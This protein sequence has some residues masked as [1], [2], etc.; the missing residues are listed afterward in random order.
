MSDIRE[1]VLDRLRARAHRPAERRWP[2]ALARVVSGPFDPDA[3]ALPPIDHVA[4]LRG[5]VDDGVAY[6]EALFTADRCAHLYR[7]ILRQLDSAARPEFG[8]IHGK[9]QRLD[10]PLRLTTPVAEAL[11]L[12]AHRLA[13]VLRA[14]LGDD[15]TLVELSALQALPGAP[16][17][18]PHPDAA[19]SDAPDEARLVTV[20]VL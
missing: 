5:L 9:G 16:E 2:S 11:V 20:F 4:A 12:L 13:P 18:P 14:R 8:D 10:L 1:H 17:Q 7:E 6:G 3:E 19:H 15:A